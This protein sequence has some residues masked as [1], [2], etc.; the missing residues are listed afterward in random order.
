MQDHGE[1][2]PFLGIGRVQVHRRLAPQFPELAIVDLF[3]YP[4]I[5]ALAGYLVLRLAP[6][7]RQQAEVEA[8][9]C[10]EIDADGDADCTDAAAPSSQR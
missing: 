1:G 10:G 8:R 4:T 6:R 7:H 2:V 9:L 3:R 5:S